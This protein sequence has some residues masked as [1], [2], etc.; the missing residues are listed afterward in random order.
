MAISIIIQGINGSS[1]GLTITQIIGI[2]GMVQWGIRQSAVLE[3]EMTSVERV[4]EYSNS[5]QEST[6]QTCP[7]KKY[8]LIEIRN[9]TEKTKHF[10]FIFVIRFRLDNTP[11]KEWPHNGKIVFQNL[12]LRYSPDTS[13]VLKNLNITIES[14]EKAIDSVN[15]LISF[16]H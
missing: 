9:T 5:P 15:V 4:L 10:F 1:V 7:G 13:R 16:S 14:E 3:N 12:S 2:S 6:N 11:P 8:L